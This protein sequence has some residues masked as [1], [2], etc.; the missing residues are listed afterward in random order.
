MDVAATTC[1]LS[2][3]RARETSRPRLGCSTIAGE[4]EGCRDLGDWQYVPS[5]VKTRVTHAFVIIMMLTV[6]LRGEGKM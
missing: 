4:S 5:R 2:Y 1:R 3:E 6:C